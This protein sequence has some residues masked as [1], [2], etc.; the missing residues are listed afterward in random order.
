MLLENTMGKN[1]IRAIIFDFGRV[2]TM[3]PDESSRDRMRLLSGLDSGRFMAAYDNRRLDYDRG[4]L[5]SESY[6]KAVLRTAGAAEERISGL[7]GEFVR[8]MTGFDIASWT[9][10]RTPMVDWV[11][12]LKESGRKTAILSNMPG[13]HAKYVKRSFDW[14]DLFDVT[15]FSCEVKLIKPEP[16]IYAECLRRLEVSPEEA[17]FIDDGE[18]NVTAA[19]AMGMHGIVFH[20]LA[21]LSVSLNEFPELPPVRHTPG[22]DG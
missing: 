16:T 19:R 5:D 8:S 12:A 3:A 13:D 22:R 1:T 9:V 18:T 10:I 20:D 11:R 21:G 15:V 2:L 17:V 4:M 6:W 14:I 7:N